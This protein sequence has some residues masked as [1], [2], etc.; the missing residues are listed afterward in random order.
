[1]SLLALTLVLSSAVIHATWNLLAKRVGGTTTFVW[2]F[3]TVSLVLYAPLAFALVALHGLPVSGLGLVLVVTS[4]AL[5]AA[6]FLLLSRGY[7]A[8]DL[9]LVYPLARGT[10]PLLAIVAA[11]IFLGERP[12]PVALAGALGI[13]VGAVVLTGDPRRLLGG[14]TGAAATYALLTG[15]CIAA[16]TLVDKEAVSVARLLPLVYYWSVNL[17]SWLILT[18]Q[19]LARRREVVE[20]WTKWRW[21][22]VGI[23]VLSPLAYILVLTALSF[24]PVSYVAPAREIGILFGTIMGARWLAEGDTRRRLL[25][26]GVMVVGIILLSI[27]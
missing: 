22:A 19:A 21:E 9:S 20:A 5:H 3:D 23:G 10:G 15:A 12:G 6:Y 1:M 18:P 27:G 8:G 7:R 26:A 4:A 25:G 16:Y 17:G 24:S 2:L 14:V 13:I 11:I